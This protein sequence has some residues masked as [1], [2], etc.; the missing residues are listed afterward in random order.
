MEYGPPMYN[1]PPDP[2]SMLPN[3]FYGAPMLPPPPAPYG[4]PQPAP[5]LTPS[6]PLSPVRSL[7]STP[8]PA[9]RRVGRPRKV[10]Q[11]PAA[12]AAQ[13][14][15]N[16]KKSAP[17]KKTKSVETSSDL[18]KEND[19][20]SLPTV[21]EIDDPSDSETEGKAKYRHWT[22]EEKTRFFQFVLAFDEA[23]EHRF[24]QLQK[25]PN[26]VF[27]RAAETLFPETRSAKSIGNLW[28][29]SLETFGWMRLDGAR[30]AGLL[31]GSLK[32]STIT[33]WENQGWWDLFNNRLGT[34][35]KVT[36]EVV[37][38]SA[39]PLS[40]LEDNDDLAATQNSD[41]QIDPT[42]RHA[43]APQ[44]PGASKNPA[45]VV[46]EP[47]HTPASAFRTQAN[48][49]LGNMGEFLKMKMVSEEVAG[50]RGEVGVGALEVGAGARAGEDGSKS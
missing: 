27:K 18:L 12:A 16:K 10:Q 3:H 50:N 22:D 44:T 33:V 26:R 34:S 13:K 49:S 20:P 46:S 24:T 5:A 21:I 37:R 29:R 4:P 15:K 31:V 40:D 30:K 47:K 17:K 23:G 39:T 7:P 6:A 19:D 43:A 36:R 9:R 48:S 28:S 38:N 25:N 8:T 14:P 42:L 45:T 2:Y 41:D 32:P 11:A 1:F 35:A